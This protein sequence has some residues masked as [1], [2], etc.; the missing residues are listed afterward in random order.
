MPDL[1]RRG[2]CLP[3]RCQGAGRLRPCHLEPPRGARSGAARG[4][5]CVTQPIWTATAPAPA[6]SQSATV[7]P[8]TS[9][10]LRP[11]EEGAVGACPVPGT[12][13]GA[14]ETRRDGTGGGRE[15]KCGFGL[16]APPTSCNHLQPLECTGERGGIYL[17]IVGICGQWVFLMKTICFC[18]FP[19]NIIPRGK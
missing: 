12:S 16:A 14:E 1:L 6:P 19:E 15:P 13:R 4:T 18:V 17:F 11:N 2:H 9:G 5:Q 10:P 8:G 3:P 7:G